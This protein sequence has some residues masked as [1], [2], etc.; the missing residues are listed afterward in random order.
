MKIKLFE[1]SK[2]VIIDFIDDGGGIKKSNFRKIFK[3]G[4][5]TKKRGW[6]LGLTLVYRIIS[7][8]HKGK[9]FVKNSLKNINTTI[10]IEFKKSS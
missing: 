8:Y 9:I 10:R 7:D 2:Y 6:G 5:T 4:Y 1:N 3:P